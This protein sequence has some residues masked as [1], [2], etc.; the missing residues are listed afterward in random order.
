MMAMM[1]TGRVLLV[2]ALCVLWCGLSGISADDV[3]DG[4][5]R[6]DGITD[7]DHKNGDGLYSSDL[8][9]PDGQA[10]VAGGG[11]RGSTSSEGGEDISMSGMDSN[12]PKKD[13]V[14]LSGGLTK[15]A[16]DQ[17][18]KKGLT[19]AGVDK[20]N[21]TVSPP[22]SPPPLLTSSSRPEGEAAEED[23][24]KKMPE[25]RENPVD[26]LS[27]Q[28]REELL[29]EELEQREQNTQNQLPQTKNESEQLQ[30]QQ[31]EKE[32]QR[33][34][35]QPEHQE[36]LRGQ[37]RKQEQR[38]EARDRDEI[39]N[40]QQQQHEHPA[41]NGKEYAKDKNAIHTINTTTLG[42]SDGSTAVSHT[43]SPLLLLLLVVACAA[44]AAVL[45]A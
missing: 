11:G 29:Q 36:E 17:Y 1:M 35:E 9:S 2:C 18:E 19:K 30:V 44:A 45:A 14:N 3:V 10:A 15:I 21:Q 23:E 37:Q 27:T 38:K 5:T 16:K 7:R 20:K 24:L 34:E 40:Q 25:E 26:H 39:Q 43:T 28:H 31:E 32:N 13:R 6:E 12:T 33:S 42:D 8:S 41:E 22:G 4:G